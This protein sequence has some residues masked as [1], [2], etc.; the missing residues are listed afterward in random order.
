MGL[1]QRVRGFAGALRRQYR[2]TDA[3]E[4]PYTPGV[5][6]WLGVALDYGKDA[7]SF[8]AERAAED[9]HVFS[10]FLAGD[11]VTFVTDPRD[12]SAILACKTLD[13]HTI[14]N[15]ISSMAFGH[16][17]AW[18]EKLDEAGVARLSI[19][20]M[21]GAALVDMTARFQRAFEEVVFDHPIE[22]TDLYGI[23][24]D[25]VFPSS[26]VA[27]FGRGIDRGIDRADFEAVDDVFP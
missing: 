2:T 22:A 21:R 5:L 11:R 26:G 1:A 13:F 9:G 7:G 16:T 14:A 17:E 4:A 15:R 25:L 6:P 12:Y 18:A 19:D 3:G 20:Q 8:L 10:V 27:V 24:A 23:I